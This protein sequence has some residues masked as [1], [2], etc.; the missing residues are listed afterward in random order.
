[1][2]V[3][4]GIKYYFDLPQCPPDQIEQSEA[5]LLGNEDPASHDTLQ[6]IRNFLFVTSY[7]FDTCIVLRNFLLVTSC[8][9]VACYLFIVK[10][11]SC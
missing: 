7:C 8:C 5:A 6:V 1:M 4:D 2:A 11:F 10:C 3:L 9:F